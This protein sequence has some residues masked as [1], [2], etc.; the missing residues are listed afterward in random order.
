M[1]IEP[2]S[3]AQPGLWEN[4]PGSI[5]IYGTTGSLRIFHYTNALF[6]RN[7]KGS[8]RIDLSGRPAFGHFATQLESCIYAITH[9]LRP[10]VSGEDGVKALKALLSVYQ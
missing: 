8:R 2:G 3:F 7:D 1:E 10:D 5:S 9:D 4:E 6:I